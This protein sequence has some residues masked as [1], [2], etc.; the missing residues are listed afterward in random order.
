[1]PNR[2]PT[3][4][5]PYLFEG[6]PTPAY[7]GFYDDAVQ[8]QD[9]KFSQGIK[10]SRAIEYAKKSDERIVHAKSILQDKGLV[11]GRPANPSSEKMERYII[12]NSAHPINHDAGSSSFSSLRYN[13]TARFYDLGVV[14]GEIGRLDSPYE[15]LGE[16][17]RNIAEVEF[18]L[19]A[20]RR[21]FLV[22]GFEHYLSPTATDHEGLLEN[23]AA[24]LNGEFGNR[25]ERHI[26]QFAE[27]FDS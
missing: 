17:G 21:L 22:P 6:E 10:S 16:I 2:K 19:K 8:R 3:P 4:A 15:L 7:Y 5:I 24:R 13:D 23:Y 9:W 27:G 20:E 14:L 1:M 11:L 26:N 18:T 25:F 12:P